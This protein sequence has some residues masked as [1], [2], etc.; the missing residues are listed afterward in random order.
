MKEYEEIVP[1][2]IGIGVAI[3][4]FWAITIG[5]KKFINMP[6]KYDSINVDSDLRMQKERIKNVQQLQKQYMQDQ[7][8]RIRDLQ[9]L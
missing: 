6:N 7:K 3:F 1:L 4:L 8:Q 5:I 2:I 9:R